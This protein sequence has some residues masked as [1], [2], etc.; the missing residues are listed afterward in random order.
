M[1]AEEPLHDVAVVGF[2]PVGQA[3]TALLGRGGYSVVAIE[4]WPEIFPLPRAGHVDHEIMRIFQSL[5]AADEVDADSWHLTGYELR[6][7]HDQVIAN[8]DWGHGGIS[9]WYSDYSLFQPYLEKLLEREALSYANVELLRSWQVEGLEQSDDEVAVIARH[10]VVVEGQW[11]PSEEVRP[12]RARYVVGCDGA[13]SIVRTDSDI[14]F[15]NLGF[16]M[17]WLVVFAE[18]NDP[19]LR[20][21]M[22]DVAQLLDPDRPTTAFRSSGKR[23][24]RWEFML[25]PGETPESM[26]TEEAAWRLIA[27]WGITPENSR[28]VRNTVFRFRST[29]ADRWRVG[30]A[31]VAG[32]AAHL[33][34]PFL[35]QGMCSGL[36]DAK[37]LA[38]KLRLVLDGAAEPVLL[39]SYEPE[40]RP[41][42]HSIVEASLKLG[43]LICVTDPVLAEQRDLALRSGAI[44][45]PAPMPSLRDGVLRR[46]DRGEL[47]LPAGE[48]SMQPTLAHG[49]TRRLMDDFAGDGWVIVATGFDPQTALDPAS[50]AVVERLGATLLQVE[51]SAE[52]NAD[53]FVDPDG[54]YLG[55]LAGFEVG[56]VIVRP[57]FYVFGGFSSP[58]EL[59][60]ALSDLAQQLTL[61]T[62][63]AAV[64]ETQVR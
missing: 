22:P 59:R 37:T 43:E 15:V 50:V 30:R 47:L 14:D 13:N 10:G 44:S 56:G 19:A 38:W 8:M 34:P 23:F 60:A 64:P 58:E 24:C 5:S 26:S 39:D 45:P 20:V 36:R 49:G 48:L 31:F 62:D 28:L 41:H 40:R 7:R 29:V 1:S 3:M 18:P 63:A 25:K 51:A 11:L 6:D 32:D 27:K 54:E 53:A 46:D 12:I 17:D 55:W 33:M 52:G 57:D 61:K 4:R 21:N 16:E 9:G 35:G 42:V 2:G